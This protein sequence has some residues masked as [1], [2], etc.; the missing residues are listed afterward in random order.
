M[1]YIIDKEGRLTE[2]GWSLAK[3]PVDPRLAR[4]LL[5]ASR[6]QALKEALVIVSGLSIQDP[7]DRPVQAQDAADAPGSVRGSFPLQNFWLM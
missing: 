3:L 5:E 6:R 2:I 1:V 4:M 7:R